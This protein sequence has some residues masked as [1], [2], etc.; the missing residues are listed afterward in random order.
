[1][2]KIKIIDDKY[3]Y[4]AW[5]LVPKFDDCDSY[6][7]RLTTSDS[8]DFLD[9]KKY[10]LDLVQTTDL[11]RNVY[12]SYN[13]SIYDIIN[14]IG[15][16]KS[17]LAEIFCI[18]KHTVENWYYGVRSCPDYVKLMI[19]RHYYLLDLG[20]GIK[21]KSEV[22]RISLKPKIY[23][24]RKVNKK[25]KPNDIIISKE[26]RDILRETDYIREIMERR[27]K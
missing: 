12:N 26:E 20:R 11:L 7:K 19:I 3:F 5:R 23:K 8:P 27:Y 2:E 13:T 15:I 24:Q 1:M 14:K 9:F 22:D 17:K 4:K 25:D 16:S 21:L 6:L 18:P 10:H